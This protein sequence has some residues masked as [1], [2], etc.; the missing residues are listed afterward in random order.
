M[1]PTTLAPTI[2][3]EVPGFLPPDTVGDDAGTLIF[4]LAMFY[5]MIRVA[6]SMLAL[7]R[8]GADHHGRSSRRGRYERG[9]SAIMKLCLWHLINV[10]KRMERFRVNKGG[11][12]EEVSSLKNKHGPAAAFNVYMTLV[13]R[14]K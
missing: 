10:E 8:R 7:H 3:G 12:L 11:W 9:D 5:I 14:S 2:V 13:S 6:V 1:V 4:M